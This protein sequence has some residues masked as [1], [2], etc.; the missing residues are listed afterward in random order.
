MEEIDMKDNLIYGVTALFNTPDEIIHAA[1]KTAENYKKYDVHT[2]YPIHGM[3]NAMKLNPSKLG[4]FA[5]AFGLTGTTIALLFMWWSM[6]WDYPVVIGGKPFFSLPAF[7]PVTFELT[8]LLASVGSVLTML[9]LLFKLPNNSHPLHDT[10]YMQ[11]VSY[12][13]F[14]VCIESKD[15][16]FNESIV[17]EFLKSLGGYNI[18]TVYY[19]EEL[20]NFRPKLFDKKFIVFLL[21]SFILVSGA[22]YFTLNKL[23]LMNPFNW[24]M[25][26]SKITEQKVS[27]FFS[28][29]NGMRPPVEGTVSR[30][31]M[32]FLYEKDP[33]MSGKMMVNPLISS[34][35][36]LLKGEKKFNTFCSPCHGFHGKGDSRLNNQFP[37]PPSLHSEKVKGWTDGR[38]YHVIMMGQGIMPS[39]SSQVNQEEVWSIIN[40]IRALQRALNANEGDMK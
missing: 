32:P 26:Q 11:N 28:D 22:T 36:V 10:E 2:P 4:Y 24:M 37:N 7:I 18:Q 17:S 21:V 20:T 19:T 12:D 23:L 8:V 6:S 16:N 1:E 5:L 40:Y 34:K 39:Y 31:N 29:G 35:E 14:G 13:K 3:P 30:G 38:I 33:E 27:S 9:F 15:G 25:V